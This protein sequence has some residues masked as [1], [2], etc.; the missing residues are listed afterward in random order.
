VSSDR[1]SCD[2]LVIGGGLA[3]LT[4]AVRACELGLRVVL[5]E[6]GDGDDYPCNSRWSGGILH[7]GFKDP[8]R[9][10]ED[11]HAFIL[12]IGGGDA[13]DALAGAIARNG[14]RL[15]DWLQEHGTRFMRFNTQEAYRWC[16]APPRS[17]RAGNDWRDR[18]PDLLIRDLGR[19]LRA[20]GG[21]IRLGETVVSLLMD[22]ERCIG[23]VSERSG[24]RNEWP[25]AFTLI[26]DGGFQSDRESFENYI[27]ADFDRVFQ[28]GARSGTGSGL[29]LGL[30]AGAALRGMDRFYGHLLSDDA[31]RNDDVWPYPELDAIATAG[32]VVDER[33]ERVADEGRGGVHLTNE[34]ARVPGTGPLHAVFDAA[35]WE[36]PGSSARIP[37]NP[38]LE[39]AGG[40]V[41]RAATVEELAEKIGAD[42]DRLRNTVETHNRALAE[43]TLDRLPIPRSSRIKPWL[44][45]N[46][47]FMAIRLCPGITYTMGGLAIDDRARV[48]RDDGRTIPGLLAAGATTGGLEGG[49]NA[50]YVGGL[51]KAGVFGLLAAETAAEAFSGRAEVTPRPPASSAPSRKRPSEDYPILFG[52][53]RF[54]RPVAVGL[55][56]AAS[57]SVLWLG[58]PSLGGWTIPFA[59][60]AGAAAGGIA[61]SYAELVRLVVTVM[62]PDRDP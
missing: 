14:S 24:G 11:L 55:G 10:P 48:L 35:I 31:R 26:A 40:T 56:A 17:L 60:A 42:P 39:K 36:G 32:I 6:K 43:G 51:M 46:G 7:I 3:G 9:P 37:A 20:A 54:G 22:G 27:G 53:M 62:M 18:G 33:G 21:E 15:L 57:G 23:A 47:P 2:L 25:A 50:A 34:L 38:L 44:V 4:A 13:D 5:L 29:R 30:Q 16:I 8:R 45:A 52:I 12:K 1:N 19:R 59:F 58:W 49:R 61:L 28:R 41:I